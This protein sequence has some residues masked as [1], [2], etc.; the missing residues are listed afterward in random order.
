M[1]VATAR[2]IA[3]KLT[4]HGRMPDTPVLVIENGTRADERR[5]LTHL[6]ALADTIAATPPKGPALVII[7][8][9]AG[10]YQD[11]TAIAGVVEE[12]MRL[13]A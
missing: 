4:R 11:Q 3:D 12:A 7:G 1:G 5:T 10:L 2:E 9:V 13:N 8:E 6:G